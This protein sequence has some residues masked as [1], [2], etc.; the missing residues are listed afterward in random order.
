MDS[1]SLP[2][3]AGHRFAPITADNTSGNLWISSILCLLYCSL[4]LIVRLHIKWKLHGADDVTVT[5]A[6]VSRLVFVFF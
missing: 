3:E 4:A 1:M 5:I 2:S 6:T